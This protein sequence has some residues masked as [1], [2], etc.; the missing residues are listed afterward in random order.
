MKTG[1]DSNSLIRNYSATN[2]FPTI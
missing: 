2:R 1:N